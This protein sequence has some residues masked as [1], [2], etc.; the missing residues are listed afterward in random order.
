MKNSAYFDSVDGIGREDVYYFDN[1][2]TDTEE[3]NEIKLYLGLMISAGKPVFIIDYPTRNSKI[4]D[5]YERSMNDG[6][7]A[8]VGPRD[9][10]KLRYY[11][12]AM[13]D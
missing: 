10:H 4:Y 8:Y 1:T 11:D 12:F 7:I 2:D 3:I 5:V 13:P 9:L 6:Y